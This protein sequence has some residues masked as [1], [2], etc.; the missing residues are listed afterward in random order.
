MI[1]LLAW[2]NVWRNKVRS[3][4]VLSAIAIGLF[5]V[6]FVSAMSTGMVV[7][8]ISSS[9]ENEISDILIRS[10]NYSLTEDLTDTFQKEQ[11]ER[12]IEKLGDLVDAH[13]YRVRAE[14]MA[15]SANHSVQVGMLAVDPNIEP[16]VTA[17]SQQ[18]IEGQYFGTDTKLKEIVV[19]R[20]LLSELKLNLESKVVLSFADAKGNINY[21]S[22]RIVGVFK[23]NSS[24]FDKINAYVRQSEVVPILKLGDDS[25]HELAIRCSADNLDRVWESVGSDLQGYDVRRWYEVNPSLKAM[26]GVMDLSTYIMVLVVLIALIFGIINTMLMVVMERRK[27]L[28]MLRALGMLNGKIATMIMMET[29]LLSVMGG[30]LGNA[31]SFAA[32]KWFGTTGIKFEDAAKGLESFGVGDTVYP[33]LPASTYITITLLV[34]ATA[35]LASVMPVRRAVRQDIADTLRN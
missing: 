12:A 25:F 13:S 28:G 1:A 6:I 26:E 5:G 7:R 2:R 32:I 3:I 34:F 29:V 21:E 35:L 16:S 15:A 20:E 14:A 22:F 11:T 10:A 31:L 9:V 4:V 30:I 24:E 27:E 23:T 17:I 19:G 33:A 8:L 18:I